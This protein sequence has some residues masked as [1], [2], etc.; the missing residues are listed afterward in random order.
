MSTIDPSIARQAKASR[1]PGPVHIGTALILLFVG[2]L[3]IGFGWGTMLIFGEGDFAYDP[4]AL[5]LAALIASI[6]LSVIGTIVWMAAVLKR[7]EL[8]MFYGFGA[9]WFGTGL[10]LL[11]A[12]AEFEAEILFTFGCVALGIAVFFVAAGF[13]A[14]QLR[15]AGRERAEV[16]MRTGTRVTGTVSDKGYTAFTESDR[17]L[18][19]VTFTFTDLQGVQRWVQRSMLIHVGAPVVEG[20][21]TDVWFDAANPGNDRGIVVRLAHES[22]LR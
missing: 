5:V 18:T 17:I 9:S 1:K 12:N 16:I 2:G 14:A 19:T 11:A 10:G 7:R 8:G 20:Q 22:P 21:E 15:R 3:A 13:F 4:P 6:P